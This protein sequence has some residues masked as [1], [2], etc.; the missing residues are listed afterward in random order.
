MKISTRSILLPCCNS[1]ISVYLID[2]DSDFLLDL[3]TRLSVEFFRY[4]A[5]K[6]PKKLLKHIN[7]QYVDNPFIKRTTQELP[8]GSRGDRRIEVQTSE[9]YHEVR[10]LERFEQVGIVIVDVQMPEMDGIDFCKKLKNPYI[11]KI[12]LTGTLS[13]T[14]AISALNTGVVHQ[15]LYKHPTKMGEILHEALLRARWSY[16]TALTRAMYGSNSPYNI[17]SAPEDSAFAKLL[18]KEMQ[19]C[20][21][22][23]YYLCDPRGT[24]LLLD[25]NGNSYGLFARTSQQLQESYSTPQ[26]QSVSP[27]L[28]KEL[29]AHKK[30]LCYFHPEQTRSPE[31]GAWE[32]YVHATNVFQGDQPLFY[33]CVPNAIPITNVAP[34]CKYE[35][36]QDAMGKANFRLFS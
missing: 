25:A 36:P 18:E 21:A 29:K 6:S 23:E 19:R 7:K 30:M 4:E 28:L 12:M 5:S 34:F 9:I 26:A 24:F 16:F 14:D 20:K 2:D 8:L 13:E 15:V 10:R 1:P 3:S 33:A 22:V 32:Q 31:G 17:N 35:Q 11:Q 27:Q